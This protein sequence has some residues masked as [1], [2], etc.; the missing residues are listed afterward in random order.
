MSRY[1]LFCILLFLLL[2]CRKEEFVSNH[3]VEQIKVAKNELRKGNL[4][5]YHRKN[6]SE[7]IQYFIFKKYGL[8][9]YLELYPTATDSCFTSEMNKK[10]ETKISIDRVTKD[11]DSLYKIEESN[12]D[13]SIAKKN[14]YIN[15]F[16]DD[17]SSITV[18]ITRPTLISYKD[19]YQ[20]DKYLIK[21]ILTFDK[22]FKSCSFWI[23]INQKGDVE[24]IEIYKKHSSKITTDFIIKELS[25]TKWKPAG[26]KHTHVNVR[27][28]IKF[29]LNNN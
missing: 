6:Y 9:D 18:D 28:R 24:K 23:V 8:V 13:E 10:I 1:S 15:C 14:D 29:S 12:L 22:S 26:L 11:I 19:I 20:F 27:I 7:A 5:F 4:F 21:T 2:S 17:I 3:C 16:Y 25:K